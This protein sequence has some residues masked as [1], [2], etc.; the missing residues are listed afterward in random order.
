MDSCVKVVNSQ[1]V[2]S[3]AHHRQPGNCDLLLH[4]LAYSMLSVHHDSAERRIIPVFHS[5][6][7]GRHTH[8]A[9]I[10]EAARCHVCAVPLN[11]NGPNRACMKV[12]H[13]DQE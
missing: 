1:P 2:C 4:R 13:S 5:F 9:G 12:F 7:V 6:W 3:V 8:I 10:S 11:A